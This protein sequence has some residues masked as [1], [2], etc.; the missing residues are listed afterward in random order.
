MAK[1]NN[2]NIKDKAFYGELREERNSKQKSARIAN[3]AAR[4]GRATLGER[5]GE[6]GSY[7]DWTVPQLK[8]RAKEIGLSGYSSKKKAELIEALRNS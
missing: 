7:E 8:S 5:G 1:K 3:A 6:S 4:E 2:D